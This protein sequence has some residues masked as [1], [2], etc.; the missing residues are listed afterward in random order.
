M[1]PQ[2]L[3]GSTR[4]AS[5]ALMWKPAEEPEATGPYRLITVEAKYREAPSIVAAGAL[6]EHFAGET[7]FAAHSSA[8][9]TRYVTKLPIHASVSM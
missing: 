8:L 9:A 1:S 2:E 5:S 3:R 7:A 6:E 4:R